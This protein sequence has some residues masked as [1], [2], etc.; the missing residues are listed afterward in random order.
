MSDLT[1]KLRE[2]ADRVTVALDAL[3][4]R[5]QGPETKLNSAIRYAALGGGKRLRPFFTLEAGALF[6]A[7]IGRASCRERVYVLV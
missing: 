2:T 1:A 6:E 4:P 5:D 3:L 7:E